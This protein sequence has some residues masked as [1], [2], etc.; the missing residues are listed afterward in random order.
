MLESQKDPL[1]FELS[2]L[3]P[4]SDGLV[5]L[6]MPASF[7]YHA[8]PWSWCGESGVSVISVVGEAV[9]PLLSQVLDHVV[10][11]GLPVVAPNF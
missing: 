10:D 11:S 2:T 3:P 6:I 1:E 8:G 7:E 9:R 5:L 4:S